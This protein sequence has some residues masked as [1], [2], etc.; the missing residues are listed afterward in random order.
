MNILLV[1]HEYPPLEGGAA[2]VAHCVARAL[3]KA[4]HRVTVV[5]AGEPDKN[6]QPVMP[7]LEDLPMIPEKDWSQL[8]EAEKIMEAAWR[9]RMCGHV[10]HG[11]NPP[12]ECP[13]CFA[14]A[15]A[16]KKINI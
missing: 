6:Y 5:T 16:F 12:D 7:A 14:D 8:S 13:Y 10:H 15:A 11:E 3:V 1:N 9:C 4:G 2:Q